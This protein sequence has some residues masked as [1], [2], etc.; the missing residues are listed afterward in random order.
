MKLSTA[1]IAEVKEQTGIDPVPE[2]HPTTPNL[3]EAFGEHTFFLDTNGLHVL[4]AAPDEQIEDKQ[5]LAVIRVASWTDEE[6]TALA[7]HEPQVSE[8]ALA[9]TPDE[10]GD[11][12]G[13]DGAPAGN[14]ASD[15]S[16][17]TKQ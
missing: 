7:P 5:A 3:K 4:E 16:G 11:S 1:Q 12:S 13:G 6:R 9:V 14:G 15:E 17:E 2:E 8:A 10:E